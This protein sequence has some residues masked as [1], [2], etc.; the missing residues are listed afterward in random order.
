METVKT[1][2]GD[3]VSATNLTTINW[4]MRALKA[5]AKLEAM[6]LLIICA[7][8]IVAAWPRFT[9]RTVGLMTRSIDTLKQA[10]DSVTK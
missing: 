2:N 3:T 10:I 6:E 7:Q 8:D 9:L 5:E 4:Q 1:S